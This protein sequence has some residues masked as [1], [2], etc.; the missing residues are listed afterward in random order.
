MLPAKESRTP[1]PLAFFIPGL[2]GGGAQRVFVTLTNALVHMTDHPIHL[3]T[4]R[5]GGTFENLVD[6]RVI[7]VV[8]GQTRVSRSVLPLARYIREHRPVAMVSTL[9]YCNLVFLVST[10][11]AGI[12]LRKIVREANVI[13][14]Q[15]SSSWK[16]IESF[17]LRNLMRVLYRRADHLIIIT[18]DVERSLIR[19][20]IGSCDRMHRIPN[21]V[22][23][24]NEP[25]RSFQR[26]APL[27]QK[28]ILGIGRLSYQK[29]FDV[30]IHAFAEL[31]DHEMKLVILGVG[32]LEK[33][34]KALTAEL[35]VK[36]RTL[37]PGFVPNPSAYLAAASVFVLPS[38]WEGFSNVLAEAL[39]MGTPVVA[40][41]CPGSPREVLED[42]RLGRLV[43]VGK[44]R[45]LAEAI[46][47]ELDHPSA[48]A[49]ARRHR[50]RQYEPRSIAG[51][52]LQ[53]MTGGSFNTSKRSER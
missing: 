13:P 36:D 12:P 11:L 45:A 52:Y 43:P 47:R 23:V 40:S 16:A 22:A 15:F 6:E 17:G 18:K 41:D 51:Q 32:P 30:L 10:L 42:G 46:A 27:P 3:V 8:L 20:R 14:D 19:H 21:P 33:Q 38:R 9:D 4:A 49:E 29:G 2:N 39:A 53:L 5:A 44:S 24:S 37:F 1:P 7:R 48:T 35:G 26:T 34:L 25:D 31:A 50:A 28:F